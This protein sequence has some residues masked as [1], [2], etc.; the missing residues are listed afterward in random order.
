MVNQ[1][2]VDS[3]AWVEY[4]L[5]SKKGETL[6]RLL[7]DQNNSFFTAECCLAEIYDWT[8]RNKQDFDHIFKVIRADSTILSVNEHDWIHAGKVRFV[9]RQ[10]QKDFG[11]IDS[12]LLVKQEQMGCILISGDKHF[13]GRKNVLF[14]D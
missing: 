14:L 8:L 7:T 2:L 12:M 11:L 9:E 3:Y 6:R 10:T 13:R 4:F 5:G 1:Y